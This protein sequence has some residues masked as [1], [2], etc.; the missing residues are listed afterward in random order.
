MIYPEFQTTDLVLAAVLRL[1]DN[2]MSHIELSG[3]SRTRGI[4]HFKSVDSQFL[5]DFQDGNVRVE[6]AEYHMMTRRLTDSIRRMVDSES[7]LF[8][9][10]TE[11]KTQTFGA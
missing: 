2:E 3:K 6:P 1:N 10:R 11:K 8:N 5:Q 7:A 9:V 4:F